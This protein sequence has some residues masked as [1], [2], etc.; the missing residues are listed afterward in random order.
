VLGL[1]QSGK[2]QGA[3]LEAGGEKL[4]NKGFFV[5]PT[6]FSNTREDMDIVS[7]EIFGPVVCAMPFKV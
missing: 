4:G 2:T 5:K 7:Q 1:I 3:K 6:V